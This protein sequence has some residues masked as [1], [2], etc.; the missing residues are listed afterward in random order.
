MNGPS[1]NGLIA[2]FGP[3]AAAALCMLC[4]EALYTDLSRFEG[5]IGEKYLA[6]II[7]PGGADFVAAFNGSLALLRGA[8]PYSHHIEDLADPLGRE[9]IIAGRWYNSI[10]LPT[11]LA[12]Y[13][14]LAVVTS[15]A[16]RKAV[17]LWFALNL[18]WLVGL[19]AVTAKLLAEVTREDFDP[20]L[21]LVLLFFFASTPAVELLLE[22]GQSDLFTALLVW[23][24]VLLAL[25]D[26]WFAAVF[27]ST[28]ALLMKG[29]PVLFLAG[30]GLFGLRRRKGPTLAGFLAAI[31]ILLLPVVRY[32]PI[33]LEAARARSEL[34]LNTWYSH[35]FQNLVYELAPQYARPGALV[36]TAIG[37]AGALL[38]WIQAWRS[39]EGGALSLSWTILFTIVSFA[40]MVGYSA[41]SHTYNLILVLPG[42]VVIALGQREL[43]R[44]LG[45]EPARSAL[46]MALLL[47]LSCLILVKTRSPTFPLA[48]V[49]LVGVNLIGLCLAA[50]TLAASPKR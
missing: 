9:T 31:V 6:T 19:S 25:R 45:N 46:G 38:C 50:Y 30:L 23:G 11:H 22:R 3:W 37:A 42:T 28:W 34:F 10:Y 12:T 32:L 33:G 14:P 18:V 13:V 49:G 47:T 29:Y 35:G 7:Q 4:L 5:P 41:A 48:S 36:L 17:H 27:F 40:T 20:L 44:T 15:G 21:A 39:G 8:N 2:R 24:A 43:L 1:R 16:K 26:R